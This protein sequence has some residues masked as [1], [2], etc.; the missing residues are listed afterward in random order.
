MSS[1]LSTTV[2]TDEV[3]KYS[4]NTGVQIFTNSL[5]IKEI[6]KNSVESVVVTHINSPSD[7]YLQLDA[8]YEIMKN[9]EEE[10][11]KFIQINDNVVENIEMSELLL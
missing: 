5:S 6:T 10:I 9:I 2:S 3:I 7:F 1:N 11:Y 8:N 4:S